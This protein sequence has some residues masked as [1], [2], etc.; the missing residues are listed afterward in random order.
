[1][2]IE[3]QTR[4][5]GIPCIARV[6]HYQSFLSWGGSDLDYI[7]VQFELLDRRG[8]P[9]P[10]LEA[11]RNQKIDAQIEQDIIKGMEG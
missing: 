11:K 3:I 10:W 4:C 2:T 5:A 6:A 1:M 8:R 7:E 9:A